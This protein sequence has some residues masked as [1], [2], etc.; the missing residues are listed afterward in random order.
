MFIY[1]KNLSFFIFHFSL[2]KT[3]IRTCNPGQTRGSAPTITHHQ[4][5]ITSHQYTNTSMHGVLLHTLRN[6]SLLTPHSSL[7]IIS[8][9]RNYAL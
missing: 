7:R 3:F 9:R 2:K 1:S 4:S 5:P 6:S 8:Q